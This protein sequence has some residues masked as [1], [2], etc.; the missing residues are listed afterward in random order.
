MKIVHFS[1]WHGDAMPLPHADLYVCTGDMLPNFRIFVFEVHGVGNV[2]WEQNMDLLGFPARGKPQA[3]LLLEKHPPHAD[4]EVELQTRYLA[5]QGRGYG[6]RWLGNPAAPVICCRGNHDF[7]DLAPMFEG[8]PM[9]E[10]SCDPTRTT[11]VEERG[12]RLSIGGVRGVKLHVNQWSDVLTDEEFSDRVR[13]LPGDL[14]VLVTHSPP[15]GILDQVPAGDRLG[16]PAL[17]TYVARHDPSL[18]PLRAHLFGHI[19][20]SCGRE[21]RGGT[22]FSNAALGWQV[23]DLYRS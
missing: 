14:D 11:L 13:G 6:R 18:P 15:Y 9:F 8:G 1:D 19:H 22:W 17:Q 21:M 23:I 4:R 7:V 10:I 12:L 2:E 5:L 16:S 3:G 20:E